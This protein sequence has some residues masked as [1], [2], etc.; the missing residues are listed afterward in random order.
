MKNDF[1]RKWK[2][3]IV[4]PYGELSKTIIARFSKRVQ[5]CDPKHLQLPS[6]HVESF[7]DIVLLQHKNILFNSSGETFVPS[8]RLELN[9]LDTSY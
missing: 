1:P 2:C 7:N 3:M 4:N 9:G 6:L 5:F 8:V